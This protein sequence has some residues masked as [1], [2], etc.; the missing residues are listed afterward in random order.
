MADTKITKFTDDQIEKMATGLNRKGNPFVNYRMENDSIKN[1]VTM[2]R[3]DGAYEDLVNFRTKKARLKRHYNNVFNADISLSSKTQKTELFKSFLTRIVVE[4][5][6]RK[7]SIPNFDIEPVNR[8]TRAFEDKTKASIVDSILEWFMRVAG[9]ENVSREAKESQIAFGDRYIRPF[10]RNVKG[11]TSSFPALEDIDGDDI[12]IDPIARNI[13][14]ESYVHRAQYIAVTK[15]YSEKALV[16]RFGDW[17]LDHAKEGFMVDNT[18]QPKEK[19]KYYEVIEGQDISTGEEFVLVGGNAFPVIFRSDNL[20]SKT[21]EIEGLL[22]DQDNPMVW[23]TEYIYKDSFG[24]NVL[25]ITDNYMYPDPESPRN[26]GIVEKLAIVQVMHEIIEN[27]K[28]DNIMQ[29]LDQIKYVVGGNDRVKRSINEYRKEKRIDRGAM[30]FIPSSLSAKAMPT[31]GV[32]KFDGLTAQ[33]GQLITQ[34]LMDIAK[35]IAG[36][37]PQQLEVQKNT[38]VTQTQ[39]IEEKSVEAVEDVQ[40]RNIPQYQHELKTFLAFIIA[41]EGFGLDDVKINFT[42]YDEHTPEGNNAATISITEAVKKIADYEFNVIIDRSTLIKRSRFLEREQLLEFLQSVNPQMTP[43]WFITISKQI[44]HISGVNLPE[45]STEAIQQMTPTGGES[46][47]KQDENSQPRQTP[48]LPSGQQE[49]G[50]G[51]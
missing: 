4:L 14:S 45:I 17:I 11:K 44:A 37:D 12:M 6:M 49:A 26:R 38:A 13:K 36:V 43:E 9:Y 30:W 35:N 27:S 18:R 29:R 47:F 51:L 8:S 42:K 28:I 25:T 7:M 3:H 10:I 16:S 20:P 23:D 46:N 15:Q 24:E 34:D 21:K 48:A 2:L 22:A 33:E 50:I 41:H 1:F 40:D 19:A 32:F 5:Y 31:P 39:I